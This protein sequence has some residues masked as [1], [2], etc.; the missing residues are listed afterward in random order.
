MAMSEILLNLAI[1]SLIFL[2][3]LAILIYKGGADK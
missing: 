1:L 2:I 3:V